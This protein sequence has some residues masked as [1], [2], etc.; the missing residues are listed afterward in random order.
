MLESVAVPWVRFAAGQAGMHS[1]VSGPHSAVKCGGIQPYH[2]VAMVSL[3]D[4][5]QGVSVGYMLS[6]A[7]PLTGLH[8]GCCVLV[9]CFT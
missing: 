6:C 8:H 2:H 5:V 9:P 3:I 7:N 1:P 4:P